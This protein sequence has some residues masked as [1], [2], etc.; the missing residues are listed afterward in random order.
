MILG[1][2]IQSAGGYDL[3]NHSH[4]SKADLSWPP[5]YCHSSLNHPCYIRMTKVMLLR[6]NT[7]G[8]EDNLEM[9]AMCTPPPSVCG[10][11]FQ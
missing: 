7:L 2:G 1:E 8:R 4:Y 11:S 10:R 9:H 6:G 3:D 5:H